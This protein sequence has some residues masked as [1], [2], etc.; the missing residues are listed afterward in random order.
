MYDAELETADMFES[1]MV[2]IRALAD[3]LGAE[4]FTLVT[5][6]GY[7]DKFDQTSWCESYG[8]GDWYTQRGMVE[9]WRD[10]NVAMNT[11]NQIGG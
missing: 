11:A 5:I 7:H 4:G 8:A 9:E 6:L 1:A 10:R 3:E 2:R